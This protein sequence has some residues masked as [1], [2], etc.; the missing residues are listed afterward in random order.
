M[1]NL[2]YLTYVHVM[3]HTGFPF[4]IVSKSTPPNGLCGRDVNLRHKSMNWDKW[5]NVEPAVPV[6]RK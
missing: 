6:T 4:I 3:A 2:K 1:V 5:V